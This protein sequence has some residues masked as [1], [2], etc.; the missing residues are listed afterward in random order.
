MSLSC[1]CSDEG[2]WWYM[3]PSDYSM[4]PQFRA[5]KRCASCEQLIPHGSTVLR[6]E[7]FREWRGEIEERIFGDDG[8]QTADRWMCETCGDLYYSLTDLGYCYYMGDDVRKMVREYAE[9]HRPAAI[10]RAA[11]G[12]G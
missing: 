7:C 2:E 3:E 9:L 10:E 12:E 1:Y 8:V 11:G 5:R 6:F 4:M